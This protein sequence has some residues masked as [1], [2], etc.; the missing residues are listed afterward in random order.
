MMKA[1]LKKRLEEIYK[2][3]KVFL[4]YQKKNGSMVQKEGLV[5]IF[6]K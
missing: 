2:S 4:P 6:R 1:L 5:R 3:S